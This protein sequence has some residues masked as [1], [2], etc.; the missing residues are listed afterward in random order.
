M[1]PKESYYVIF[2][3]MLPAV[4]MQWIVMQRM[5]CLDSGNVNTAN[6]NAWTAGNVP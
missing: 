1:I 3:Y 6:E 4:E 2:K 5:K